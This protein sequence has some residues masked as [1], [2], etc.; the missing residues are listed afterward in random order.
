M[1][2]LGERKMPKCQIM[3]CR[4]RA[5]RTIMI[6]RLKFRYCVR[7]VATLNKQLDKEKKNYNP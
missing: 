2:S 7:C 3:N 5:A 4:R 6:G 1:K